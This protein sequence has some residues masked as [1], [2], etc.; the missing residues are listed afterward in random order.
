MTF[1]CERKIS[2]VSLSADSLFFKFQGPSKALLVKTA[3]IVK[4]IVEKHGGTK[5]ELAANVEAAAGLY[6]D[7]KDALYSGLAL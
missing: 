6:V 2:M 3:Q 1:L 4:E 5:F 7:W